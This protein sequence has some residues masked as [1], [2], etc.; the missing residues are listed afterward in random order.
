MERVKK[1][2]L[3]I[4]SQTNGKFGLWSLCS[5][6]K[7]FHDRLIHFVVRSFYS[8]SVKHD[9]CEVHFLAYWLKKRGIHTSN[10]LV[11]GCGLKTNEK[12]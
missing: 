10:G 3:C 6:L 5:K 8:F 7:S 9:T 4:N 2:R 12:F 11:S 1:K